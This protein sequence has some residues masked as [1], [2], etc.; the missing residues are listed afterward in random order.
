M[1]RVE[2]FPTFNQFE[3]P[4][5]ATRFSLT[6]ILS[7]CFITGVYRTLA[8]NKVTDCIKE[9][10]DLILHTRNT[11]QSMTPETPVMMAMA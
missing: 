4:L 7:A 8:L 6:L 11:A 9:R 1:A 10:T 3:S 5:P 2:G